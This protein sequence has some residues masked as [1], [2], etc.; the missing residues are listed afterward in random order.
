VKPIVVEGVTYIPVHTAPESVNKSSAIVPKKTGHIDTFKVGKI[1]YI[2]LN[3]I[4]K[5]HRQVFK[6]VK[7]VS[8][9]VIKINGKFYIPEKKNAKPI[10]VEGRT[11]IPV[12]AAP[13]HLNT[14]SSIHPKTEEPVTTFKIGNKTYIPLEVIPKTFAPAFTKKNKTSVISINGAHYI[15][16]KNPKK[17][18]VDGVTYIP[19]RKAPSNLDVHHVISSNGED[20]TTFKIGNKT[21]IPLKAIPK[22][23]RNTFSP[24]KKLSKPL[25]KPPKAVISINGEHFVP[26][27]NLKVKPV[28]IEGRTYIPVKSA[29]TSF[30][31]TKVVTPT[32]EG[33]VVTFKIG[34]RT[35]IPL[36]VVPKPFQSVFKNKKVT[37]VSTPVK[38]SKPIPKVKPVAKQPK[39]VIKINDG[40]YIPIARK[41]VKPI[42]VEGISYIPVR[43]APDYVNKSG[44]IAS[45]KNGTINTFKIGNITYIPLHV[46]PKVF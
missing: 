34:N 12:H 26:I 41:N 10:V 6:P 37:K 28:V 45:N 2:P 20:H 36:E 30:N 9:P 27:T 8:P 32:K 13:S 5:V 46:V 33:K 11:Y 18:V 16:V 4:P 31:R 7:K 39:V 43:I 3:V 14:S 24:T 15:P 35:Y 22:V 21:Y 40:H 44:A 17:I 23:Y 38:V 42:V 29:P 1:T 19:V 25:V